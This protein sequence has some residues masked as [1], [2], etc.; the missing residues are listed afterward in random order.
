[1][2]GAQRYNEGCC[3]HVMVDDKKRKRKE[4]NKEEGGEM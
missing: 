3:I 2:K 1:V 4:K